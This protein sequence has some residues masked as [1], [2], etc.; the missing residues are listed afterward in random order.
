MNGVPHKL[1]AELQERSTDS[2]LPMTLRCTASTKGKHL[3]QTI[4]SFFFC[5][6]SFSPNSEP[7]YLSLPAHLSRSMTRC[8]QE[9]SQCLV[10][11]SRQVIFTSRRT[12]QVDRCTTA[13][14][15]HTHVVVGTE[16]VA[17]KFSATHPPGSRC[18]KH[19]TRLNL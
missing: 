15:Q 12:H 10:H 11:R 3:T 6:K 7:P 5:I 13:V 9:P 19:Q 2:T 17:V 14:M 8:R 4:S 18:H 16:S 1:I